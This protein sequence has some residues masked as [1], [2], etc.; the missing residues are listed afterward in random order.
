[1]YYNIIFYKAAIIADHKIVCMDI[2][3]QINK[4]KLYYFKL[5]VNARV[6]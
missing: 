4:F 5:H 1:M 6:R 2:Y 3:T